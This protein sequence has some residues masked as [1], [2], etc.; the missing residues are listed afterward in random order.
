MMTNSYSKIEFSKSG[1][2]SI[3]IKQA[4]SISCKSVMPSYL[5][6]SRNPIGVIN[7]TSSWFSPS[8]V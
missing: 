4:T 8:A 1:F 7:S 3:L 6:P 5:T 2:V